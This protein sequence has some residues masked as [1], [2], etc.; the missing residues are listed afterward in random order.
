LNPFL[1]RSD[2]DFVIP[3]CRVSGKS[4]IH[5][6]CLAAIRS[7]HKQRRPGLWIPGP[8]YA[9]PGMTSKAVPA[10]HLHPS[11]HSSGTKARLEPT[12]GLFLLPF[13]MREAERR[14]AHPIP[15]AA[16]ERGPAAVICDRTPSGAP[17]RSCAGDSPSPTRLGPRFLESP[18]ANG[19]TLSGTSA[20][21]TSQTTTRWWTGRCPSR[22]R[23]K[24][25]E[26]RPQ[27][28]HPLRQSAS[29]VDVPHDERDGRH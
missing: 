2:V 14:M 13:I 27:E 9:R 11:C 1:L 19:R 21:S 6:P 24:S 23:A 25:D 18:D 16:P 20:A 7:E 17:P 8:R 5:M 28:P 12:R 22:L 10:M 4:G 15:I 3:D 26:L 29:P